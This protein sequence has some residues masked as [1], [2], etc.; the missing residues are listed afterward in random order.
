MDWVSLCRVPIT[1]ISMFWVPFWC[2]GP[3]MNPCVHKHVSQIC[4]SAECSFLLR[5]VFLC[6]FLLA[7]LWGGYFSSLILSPCGHWTQGDKIK[8]E[9]WS[10]WLNKKPNTF[11]YHGDHLLLLFLSLFLL[12]WPFFFQPF[13]FT[14]CPFPDQRFS[15]F[16]GRAESKKCNAPHE[17]SGRGA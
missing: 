10:S 17:E 13:G 11:L 12:P 6:F 8:L 15:I 16:R 14:P 9:K 5:C 3:K 1:T 4:V 2:F 7:L